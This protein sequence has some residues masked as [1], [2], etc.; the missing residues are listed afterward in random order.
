MGRVPVMFGIAW[1]YCIPLLPI[2]S[3]G[4]SQFIRL[5]SPKCFTTVL[6]L[7]GAVALR[8]PIAARNSLVAMIRYSLCVAHNIFFKLPVLRNRGSLLYFEYRICEAASQ[9]KVGGV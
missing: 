8:L 1:I 7:I 3:L 9:T 4:D 6:F 2:L 5:T